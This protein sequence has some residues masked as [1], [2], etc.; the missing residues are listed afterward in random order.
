MS[1]TFSFHDGKYTVTRD[2]RG[3]I[4]DMTRNGEP[5]PAGVTAF[6]FAK[7]VHAILDH[8]EEAETQRPIDMILNCP[9]CGLQH[10]D[11]PEGEGDDGATIKRVDVW[12]NPPHRSHLCHGCG[13]IW[14]P[15]DVPT[16]GVAEIQTKG[17]NDSPAPDGQP[18]TEEQGY[19]IEAIWQFVPEL[20][21]RED[22]LI[23]LTPAQL[24]TV[25][26]RLGWHAP[27]DARKGRV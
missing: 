25:L 3:L 16:N 17:K 2:D 1:K 22:N 14:R 5:W 13:H 11:E 21:A 4:T 12:T 23:V 18:M 26:R 27:C 8:I 19:A 10:I 7:F 6:A 24:E 20:K 15:A 9:A